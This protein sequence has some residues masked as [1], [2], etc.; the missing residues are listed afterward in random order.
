MGELD[1]L[2]EVLGTD[3]DEIPQYLLDD[4]DKLRKLVDVLRK[5][6]DLLLPGEVHRG[7]SIYR[8]DFS[9]GC[10][11]VGLTKQLIVDRVEQHFGQHPLRTFGSNINV[12]RHGKE[13]S[14]E[15][16]CLAS[17]L[18]KYEARV[19]EQNFIFT[20]KN[21][22]NA[23]YAKHRPTNCA[24]MPNSIEAAGHGA[25]AEY[26]RRLERNEI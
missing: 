3:A 8:I 16:I 10:S 11:Y 14:Y 20:L 2:L 12:F 17:G 6:D 26:Y 21:A 19:A 15:I 18:S 25:V 7:Y 5:A 1:E 9:D 22:L 24:L 13:Y 23:M 4:L